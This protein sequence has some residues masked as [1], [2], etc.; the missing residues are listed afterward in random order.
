[1]CFIRELRKIWEPRRRGLEQISTNNVCG[2]SFVSRSDDS[3]NSENVFRSS[4]CNFQIIVVNF[5]LTPNLFEVK[6][7]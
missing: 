4:V 6:V 3:A 7:R 5:F 2:I 1:M